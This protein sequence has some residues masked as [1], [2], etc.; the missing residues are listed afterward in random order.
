MG[1]YRGNAKKMIRINVDSLC[2]HCIITQH[3]LRYT[4]R[5]LLRYETID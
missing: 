4:A 2:D 5:H 3:A 1:Y